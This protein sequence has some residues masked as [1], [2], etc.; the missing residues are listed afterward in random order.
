MK[1]RRAFA[2]RHIDWES[3]LGVEIQNCSGSFGGSA[4]EVSI[5]LIEEPK[6]MFSGLKK[7]KMVFPMTLVISGKTMFLLS[8][9]AQESTTCS[10]RLIPGNQ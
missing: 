10:L 7:E 9:V 2:S 3:V 6:I 1:T 5:W 4:F 8:I